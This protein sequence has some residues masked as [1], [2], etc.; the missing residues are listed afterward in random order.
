MQ[1]LVR[2]NFSTDTRIIRMIRAGTNGGRKESKRKTVS[3]VQNKQKLTTTE[4]KNGE[5]HVTRELKKGKRARKPKKDQR[6]FT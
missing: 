2:R 6:R 3:S 4:E 1:N 5:G